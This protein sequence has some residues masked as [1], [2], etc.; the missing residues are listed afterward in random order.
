VHTVARLRVLHVLLRT[1][2]TSSLCVLLREMH[3]VTRQQTKPE[4]QRHMSAYMNARSLDINGYINTITVL[5]S[6]L[7][8]Q[9]FI[10]VR[11]LCEAKVQQSA[12]A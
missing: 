4:L 11:F 8:Q 3:L 5:I 9:C 2:H 1:F 6:L 12:D 10:F 7:L